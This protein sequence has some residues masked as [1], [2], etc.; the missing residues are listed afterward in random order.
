MLI[1]GLTADAAGEE[2]VAYVLE[3]EGAVE[4]KPSRNANFQS[5][6]AK[7]SLTG[8]AHIRV[9]SNGF[10]RLLYTDHSQKRIEANQSYNVGA[11]TAK[12][13]KSDGG[14]L[15]FATR[16]AAVRGGGMQFKQPLA[17]TM[18]RA[19][20]VIG[21]AVTLRW[22]DGGK[23]DEFEVI[24]FA[25]DGS[26]RIRIRTMERSCDVTSEAVDGKRGETFRWTVAAVGKGAAVEG[27][28]FVWIAE[29][30]ET[31]ILDGAK[32][33]DAP[34]DAAGTHVARAFYFESHGLFCE[35]ERELMAAATFAADQEGYMGLLS[36]LYEAQDELAKAGK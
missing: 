34:A 36:A 21:D 23:T 10:A 14:L 33:L 9:G 25:V 13:I 22:R 27:G 17:A 16:P 35:A 1:C 32:G 6:R 30:K 2:L 15:G 31:E 18:P 12:K 28:S 24:V 7:E 19:S 8:E 11:R 29:A 4:Y 3:T 26:E 5:L 20:D